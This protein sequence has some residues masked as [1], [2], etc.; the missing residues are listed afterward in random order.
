[1]STQDASG[2]DNALALTH[3]GEL[4][5][6]R[7]A[8]GSLL[9][10]VRG[11]PPPGVRVRTDAELDASLEQALGGH[12]PGE[13]LHVF[14]YGSLMWNPAM[15]V[16]QTLRAR[17][18]GWHRRFCLRMLF[19]RGTVQAPGAMLALDRGGAC[20]GLLFRI[21]AAKVR[22][23]ARLLWRREM[24]AGSYDAR[25]V[26]VRANGATLRAI[27]FVANRHHERYI[28]QA[29]IEH[30]VELI[31]TGQGTLGTSRAYFER[32]LRTLQ[33]RGVRDRG[34]ERLQRAVVQ[35]DLHDTAL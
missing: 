13:D 34:L 11:N 29:P 14:G 7:L 17:V 5:R 30:V 10:V 8:A 24:M 28:G 22:E 18:D 20:H 27:A 15:D 19:G 23:E 31:R 6:Q 1:M 12:A 2:V 32:T 9:H 33:D 26:R 4:T 35:A 16:V 25:W 21:D 3:E